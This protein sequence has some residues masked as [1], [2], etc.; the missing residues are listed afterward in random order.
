MTRG[1]KPIRSGPALRLGQGHE[2]GQGEVELLIESAPLDMRKESFIA[3]ETAALQE[4]RSRLPQGRSVR[5]YFTESEMTEI[6][7]KHGFAS[8]E[9]YELQHYLAFPPPRKQ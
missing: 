7:R 2:A 8:E 5:E 3:R 9:D 4:I 1:R 6:F